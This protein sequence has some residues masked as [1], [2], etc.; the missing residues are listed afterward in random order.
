[1]IKVLN[2]ATVVANAVTAASAAAALSV[3]VAVADTST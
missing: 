3:T 2:D 1:V